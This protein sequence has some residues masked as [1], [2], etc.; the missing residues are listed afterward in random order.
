MARS[1][2]YFSSLT[3]QELLREAHQMGVCRRFDDT[4]EALEFALCEIEALREKLARATEENA[5]VYSA[6]A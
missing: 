4:V 2:A 1:I 5:K 6:K 3:A